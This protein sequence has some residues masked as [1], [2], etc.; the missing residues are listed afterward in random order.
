MGYAETKTK[1][2]SNMERM[3]FDCQDSSKGQASTQQVECMEEENG[4][5]SGQYQEANL[6]ASQRELLKAYQEVGSTA[7]LAERFNIRQD[8]IRE[9]LKVIREKLGYD[10]IRDLREQ[11][12]P[13]EGGPS[14]A[15]AITAGFLLKLIESQDYRC[16]L[17]GREL[18]PE[19]A[20]LDHKQP[21]ADG[22]ENEP[23]NLWW[24]HQDVNRAK[25]TMAVEAF[26]DM[27]RDV[28]THRG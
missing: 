8:T 3:L 28:V 4:D 2:V 5:N 27:C 12:T 21:R 6:R 26:V 9:R 10:D 15:I 16:A 18:T 13:E 24:V 7:R 17:T 11:A 19:T 23:D 20:A 14:E 1:G 22:G 25:G